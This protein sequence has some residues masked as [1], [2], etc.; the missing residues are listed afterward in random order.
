MFFSGNT[1]QGTQL[2]IL[3]VV[4]GHQHLMGDVA[5]TEL[6][7]ETIPISKPT[8]AKCDRFDMDM[9]YMSVLHIKVAYRVPHK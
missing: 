1:A 3:A 2:R 7:V 6:K 4:T 5:R 9:S 8:D